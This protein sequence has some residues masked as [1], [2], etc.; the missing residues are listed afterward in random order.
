MVP[1][2]TVS[3]AEFKPISNSG[4]RHA[5]ILIV[6]QEPLIRMAVSDHLQNENFKTLEASNSVEGVAILESGIAQV[7]LVFGDA[8]IRG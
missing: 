8:P 1:R 2:G 3:P 7:D 5:T 6:E 4:G